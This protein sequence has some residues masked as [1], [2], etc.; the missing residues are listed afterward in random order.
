MGTKT[1]EFQGLRPE[2]TR[3]ALGRRPVTGSCWELGAGVG[4]NRTASWTTSLQIPLPRL[5]RL[6]AA[7][8]RAL[9][10][11]RETRTD[12]E[13]IVRAPFACGGHPIKEIWSLRPEEI[14]SFKLVQYERPALLAA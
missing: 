11:A 6:L 9:L 13:N 8:D 10:S 1:S 3:V 14:T 4:D 2:E 12:V 5:P 7:R